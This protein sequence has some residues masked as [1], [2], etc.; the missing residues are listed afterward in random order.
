MGAGGAPAPRPGP[1]LGAAARKGEER[2]PR[3][4]RGKGERAATPTFQRLLQPLDVHGFPESLAG[5]AGLRGPER[6]PP[7]PDAL[8]RPRTHSRTQATG[9]REPKGAG[10]SERASEPERMSTSRAATTSPP[11]W[12]PARHRAHAPRRR[13]SARRERRPGA[14]KRVRP[15]AGR[16][17]GPGRRPRGAGGG[18]GRAPR[19]R[20]LASEP[21]PCSLCDLE[22]I[23]RASLSLLYG[24][25]SRRPPHLGR[26]ESGTGHTVQ[27][28]AVLLNIFPGLNF[29]VLTDPPLRRSNVYSKVNTS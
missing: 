13:P 9:G 23:H 11:T 8:P 21:I 4:V 7:P 27:I 28:H 25:R 6:R 15:E 16:R 20:A 22:S 1:A 12:R 14:G 2:G 26:W 18:C 24:G 19:L 10:G 17:G 3:T 29:A 5:S